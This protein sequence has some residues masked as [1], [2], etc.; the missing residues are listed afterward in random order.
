MMP[1]A[2]E[3]AV[4]EPFTQKKIFAMVDQ[5]KRNTESLRSH[6]PWN[7]RFLR[8]FSRAAL[9]VESALPSGGEIRLA[10]V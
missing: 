5:R 8:T 4:R 9:V 3:F 6:M 1:R 7:D 2:A 10:T